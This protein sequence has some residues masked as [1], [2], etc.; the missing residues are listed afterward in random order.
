MPVRNAEWEVSVAEVKRALESGAPLLLI[1]V[2]EPDEHRTCRIDGALLV[3]LGELANRMAELKRLAAGK[4]VVAHCHHGGRSLSAAATLREAGL[5]GVKSMA[6]GIDEWSMLID[7]S[8]P[9]Y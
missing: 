9:R 3:P 7:A 2:R 6:G 5:A 8:V 1:D 4:T